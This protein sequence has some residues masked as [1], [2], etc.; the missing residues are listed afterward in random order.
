MNAGLKAERLLARK[1]FLSTDSHVLLRVIFLLAHERGRNLLAFWF[2]HIQACN[3]DGETLAQ[4]KIKSN[5][6]RTD[7]VVIISSALDK[8][9]HLNKGLA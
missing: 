9:G 4:F 2:V 1:T 5:R 7:F 3:L 6:N 8:H